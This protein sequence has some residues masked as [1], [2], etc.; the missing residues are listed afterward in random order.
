M[1]IPRVFFAAS[2]MLAFFAVPVQANAATIM[3]FPDNAALKGRTEVAAYA[4]RSAPPIAKQCAGKGNGG[5][6]TVTKPVDAMSPQLA[7][8]AQAKSAITMQIDDS[9][10]DGTRIAY[11]LTNATIS[12]LTP[13]AGGDK[14][15]EQVAFTYSNIQWVTVGCKPNA[16]AQR[17]NATPSLDGGA[18]AGGYRY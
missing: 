9:K 1:Y 2:A 3:D 5:S 14:P 11:Q 18:G 17:R 15:M 4:F 10:S 7:Q 13:Q 8:A 6:I 12:S 16:T